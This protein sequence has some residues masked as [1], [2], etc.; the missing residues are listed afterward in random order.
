[1][2]QLLNKILADRIQEH[3]KN[4]IPHDDH[5]GEDMEK[6]EHTSIAGGTTSWYK[7]EIVLPEDPVILLLGIHPKDALLQHKD[8]FS[9][10]LIAALCNH[11]KLEATQMSLNQRVDIENVV[12]LGNGIVFN[13]GKTK[14][15][16]ILEANG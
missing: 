16:W 1:M 5:V 2:Q 13:H 10:M 9:T 7:L 15:S 11:W 4:I 6:E 12:H 8:V 3:I 14:K